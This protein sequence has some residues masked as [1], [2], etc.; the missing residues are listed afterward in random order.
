MS[1][2]GSSPVIT[3]DNLQKQYKAMFRKGVHALKGVSFDVRPGEVFALLGPN[4]AGKTTLVKVL[5]GIIR[6]SGGTASMLGFPAGDRRSRTRVGYLPEHLRIPRHQTART[7]LDFYGKLSGM[8]GREVAAKRDGLL[9]R[10]GLAGRDR[11][12]VKRFSKGML[13]RLGLA[14]ALLHDPDVL[15]LDEPTD[16]L[17]PVGRNNVRAILDGLRAE[18]RTVFLNSHLLQEVEL[19]CDRVAILDKGTLKFVGSLEELTPTE[20]A[21]EIEISFRGSDDQIRQVFAHWE[22]AEDWKSGQPHVMNLNV[23]SQAESDSFVDRLRQAG[24]SIHSLSWRGRTL[25]DAFLK[26]V[27]SQYEA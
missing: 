15:I 11:E 17:D 7:A 25:E 26:L 16:G 24:V 4:G 3:V 2:N 27:G 1:T 5:L 10:V 21:G 23:A 14:Q 22:P 9:E 19:V 20:G 13:Q 18:G 6:R 12:S 8:S